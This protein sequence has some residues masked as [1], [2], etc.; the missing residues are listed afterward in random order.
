MRLTKVRKG[1]GTMFR[2][3]QGFLDLWAN[4][5]DETTPID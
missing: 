5:E 4:Q 3:T 2:P 1:T